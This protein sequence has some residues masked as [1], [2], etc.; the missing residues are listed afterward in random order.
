[1]KK[2]IIV[3][4]VSLM[5]FTSVFSQEE[6][7]YSKIYPFSK[8]YNSYNTLLMS[9]P[10]PYGY[11][12]ISS[13]EIIEYMAWITNL[14]LRPKGSPVY[15]WNRQ[16]IMDADSVN[17]VIDIGVGTK[18][19]KDADIP[20]QLLIEYLNVI[21]ALY[22]FPIIV[23]NGDTVTYN[24]WLNGKYFKDPRRNLIYKKGDKKEHSLKE[25]YRFLEFVMAMN[26]NKTLLRNL[27]PVK[28]KEIL[29]GDLYIQ[30]D[31]DD[32]DSTG[33]ASIIFDVCADK[34]G[35]CLYL[36]GWGGTPAQALIVARPW[37]LDKKRWFTKNELKK[38]LEEYGEGNFYRFTNIEKI[39]KQK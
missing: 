6:R 8:D 37:P 9:F 4:F 36:A 26:E 5:L 23:G 29:P 10:A 3:L 15:K 12:R 31:K 14:P 7:A 30:F 17:G 1:M 18:N 21:D 13:A 2:A 20:L 28:E 32:T 33:H 19:Q 24:N 34:K 27:K 22:Y 25:Y 16:I 11:I 38:R 35:N 39:R